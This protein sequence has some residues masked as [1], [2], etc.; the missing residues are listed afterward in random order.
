MPHALFGDPLNDIHCQTGIERRIMSIKVF[1]GFALF[2][3]ILFLLLTYTTA[4]VIFLAQQNKIDA[5]AQAAAKKAFQRCGKTPCDCGNCAPPKKD[6]K[7]KAL[8]YENYLSTLT[9]LPPETQLKV[10]LRYLPAIASDIPGINLPMPTEPLNPTSITSLPYDR[11]NTHLPYDRPN[12]LVPTVAAPVAVRAPAAAAPAANTLVAAAARP[13][14]A[15]PAAARPAVAAPAAARP[16][17]ATP[18]AAR[19][20]STSSTPNSSRPPSPATR[21]K[22]P[23]LGHD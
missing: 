18:A 5:A 19:T 20:P 7:G 6:W 21:S 1:L 8:I 4:R 3:Y 9:K 2:A 16:P 15:T 10:A 14:V 17:V 13:P 22:Q 23:W 11:P 12:T